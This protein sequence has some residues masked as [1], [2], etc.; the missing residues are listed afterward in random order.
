MCFWM[1]L[2][3]YIAIIRYYNLRHVAS[4]TEIAGTM[5]G[6][7]TTKSLVIILTQMDKLKLAM[8]T[9]TETCGVH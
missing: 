5:L 4:L 2:A 9:N 6:H 8:H 7:N 3:L 1:I